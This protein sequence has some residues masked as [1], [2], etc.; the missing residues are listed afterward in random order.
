MTESICQETGRSADCDQHGQ[1][2]LSREDLDLLRA[3]TNP[4]PT[5]DR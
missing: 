4:A 5:P 1:T 3:K 2:T